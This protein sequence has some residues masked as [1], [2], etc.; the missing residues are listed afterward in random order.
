MEKLVEDISFDADE[1]NGQLISID[2]SF[3]RDSLKSMV[4]ENDLNRYIL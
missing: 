2:A 4:K 1:R 3:V